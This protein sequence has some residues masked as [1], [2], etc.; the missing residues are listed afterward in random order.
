MRAASREMNAV[1]SVAA[2]NAG[3]APLAAEFDVARV[4]ED[5]PVL[6]REV[7]GRPLVYLD[8]AATSQKPRC[9]IEAEAE[10]Y[11][12]SNANIH[13]GVHQ[14]SQEATAAYE[15]ARDTTRRFV[16]A[17]QLEEIVFVRG[18]TEAINL[19]AASYGQRL[20]P[21][22]EVLITEME[23]HSNIVPWQLLCERSGAVLRVAPIDD[24]GALRVDEFERLLSPRK[25]IVAIAH[26]SNAL[27]TINPVRR[28]IGLAHAQGAIVLVDGAQAA[29]H[30]AV[31]V[32]ALDCD[33]YALS[34]HKLYGPTGV[35]VLYGKR[36]LLEAMPPYQGGGDMI[37][38]VTF[39]RTSYNDL[40]YKFE[41]GTPN[42][43]GVV[44]F[45]RALEYVSGLGLDRIA[46]HENEL[47][48]YATALARATPGLRLLGTAHDKASILSFVVDGVHPHDVGTILDHEGVAVRT[49]HH[50]AMPVMKHFGV[51]ASVRASIGLYNTSADVDVL[52]RALHKA[53]EVFA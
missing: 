17:A 11:A 52:F 8:N 34:S 5:F 27:G 3:A 2:A 35:G 15:K 22:D 21:G 31:D 1:R 50:C 33:F 19:V 49:G 42:I 16:N 45:G 24:A 47:L 13:R 26:V 53:R 38:E 9:V 44:A 39:E 10:Y 25:K 14:L 40:P 30:L 43:A 41:A 48:A 36:A 51:P 37:R 28:L 4:R 46:A 29:P 20:R 12:H 6:R 7:H 32:Q 18:A 23:H